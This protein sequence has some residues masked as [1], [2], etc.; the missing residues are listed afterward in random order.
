MCWC[1]MIKYIFVLCY[2]PIFESMQLMF[3]VY[4]YDKIVIWVH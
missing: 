3:Y 2:L 4:I 1:E